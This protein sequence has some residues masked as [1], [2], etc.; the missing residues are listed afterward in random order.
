MTLDTALG[1]EPFVEAHM[2]DDISSSE[3]WKIAQNND[4]GSEAEAEN[5][6][7]VD[8]DVQE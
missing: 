4:S 3:V 6:L 2:K 1:W 7:S 5:S 8:S